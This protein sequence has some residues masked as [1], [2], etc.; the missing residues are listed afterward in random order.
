MNSGA[1]AMIDAPDWDSIGRG[2]TSGPNRVTCVGTVS[3][4]F[5]ERGHQRSAI[6]QELS[7]ESAQFLELAL[8]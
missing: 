4:E 8:C 7:C 2:T 6:S 3:G 1:G 5:L